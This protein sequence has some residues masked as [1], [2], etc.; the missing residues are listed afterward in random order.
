MRSRVE[1]GRFE[2]T[3]H[4]CHDGGRLSRQRDGRVSHLTVDV[5]DP[6]PDA[7]QVKRADGAVECFRLGDERLELLGVRVIGAKQRDEMGE[8][9]LRR[10]TAVHGHVGPI[11]ECRGRLCAST[12]TV[13]DAFGPRVPRHALVLWLHIQPE[14]R[15][16]E[17]RSRL[18]MEAPSRYT[19]ATSG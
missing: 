7:F 6:E 18:Q 8:A 14:S 5:V 15:V 13:F 17:D 9:A 12:S 3:P 19:T 1:A 2:M 11:V 4:V 16:R 10:L